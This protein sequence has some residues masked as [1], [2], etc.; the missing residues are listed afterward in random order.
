MLLLSN[1][2]PIAIVG[3]RENV[4]TE[5]LPSNGLYVTLELHEYLVFSKLLAWTSLN[6]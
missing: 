1:I 2:R 4:L 3:S 6:I 5:L